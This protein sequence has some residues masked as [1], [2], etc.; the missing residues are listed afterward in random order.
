MTGPPREIFRV[1]PKG[2]Q[3]YPGDFVFDTNDA[4][5]AYREH[6]GFIRGAPEIV[7]MVVKSEDLRHPDTGKITSDRYGNEFIYIP[8]EDTK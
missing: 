4:A 3:I 6:Y 8:V 7:S 2:E 5:I 1:V